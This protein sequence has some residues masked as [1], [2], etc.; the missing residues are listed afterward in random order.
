MSEAAPVSDVVPPFQAVLYDMDGTL[1]DTEPMWA[2]SERRIMAGYGIEWTHADHAHCLG[3]S[4]DRVCRYMTGLVA[5]AGGQPPPVEQFAVMFLDLML[6]QLTAD[7]PVPQP[8]VAALLAEVRGHGIPTGLVSSSSRP[9]M[10]AV[11]SSIG[12]HWFDVT[13]SA[14]DVD[15]H[16][17]DPLPYLTTAEL[18][19]VDPAWCLA[20]EDSPP[21]V[22]S[23]LAAQAS[24]VAV[25]HLADFDPAPRLAV[26]P[27]LAGVDVATLAE[28]FVPPG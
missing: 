4:T 18:L 20:I 5:R 26:V 14:D 15:R 11:L 12:S 13:V 28:L 16:K 23:A 9:L 8:G 2:E 6:D 21:G 24:V 27:S 3:G 1:V 10:T 22:G 19:G 17:P 25:Q 7:P